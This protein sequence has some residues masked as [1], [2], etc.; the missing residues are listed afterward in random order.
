MLEFIGLEVDKYDFVV[1]CNYIEYYLGNY[2]K[3]SGNNKFGEGVKVLLNDSIEVGLLN[4]MLVMFVEFKQCCGYDLCF[5]L[6]VF[7][8]VVVNNV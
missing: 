4:W 6:F 3:V 8:G 7:I 1:V 5:W 2:V